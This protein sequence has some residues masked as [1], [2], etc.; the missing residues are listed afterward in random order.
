MKLKIYKLN[1]LKYFLRSCIPEE[2]ARKYFDK[3]KKFERSR[4]EKVNI[5]ASRNFVKIIVATGNTH[6]RERNFL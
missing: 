1:D 2:K 4:K 3:Y 5:E 6:K